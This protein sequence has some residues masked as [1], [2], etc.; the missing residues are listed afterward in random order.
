M[1]GTAYVT[2]LVV[3]HDGEPFLARTLSALRAQS[4]VPDAWVGVDAGSK[5]SSRALLTAGLPG[6][7]TVL[8]AP[9]AAFGAAVRRGVDA[10]PVAPAGTERWLW[11][12]HDD[13]APAPDALETL[14]EAIE[15]APSVTVAGTKQMDA[16][17]PDRVLDA[18]LTMTRSGRR[19]NAVAA[20]EVDQGQYDDV[21][22]VLGVNSAGL[23]VRADVFEQLDGFDPALPGVGD[24]V[25]FCRRARLSGHRVILVPAAKVLHE[26]DAVEAVSGPRAVERAAAYSCLKFAPAWAVPFLS[27]WMMIAGVG[28]AIGRLIAK[29][30]AGAVIDLGAGGTGVL[31]AGP[32]AAGR[33]RLRASQSVPRAVVRSL[34]APPDKVRDRARALRD[35]AKAEA[36]AGLGSAPAPEA[37]GGNDDFDAVEAGPRTAGSTGAGLLAIAIAAGL[38]LL[39]LHRVFGAQ[40]AAGGA[41][42]APGK[43]LGELFTAATS[44]WRELGTGQAGPADPFALLVWLSGVLS[45]GHPQAAA[46]ALYVLAMPLAA[47]G[48]F[49]LLGALTRSP[50]FRFLGAVLWALAPSLQLAL[51]Q[52]RP[53]AAV[54]HVA[55]PLF[56][57]ALV[58]SVGAARGEGLS[59]APGPGR[60]GLPSWVATCCAAALGV[61]LAAA[62]PLLL[63]PLLLLCLVGAAVSRRARGWFWIPLPAVLACLP[64]LVAAVRD[65]RVLL[66]QPG[67][68]LQ[69]DA[70]PLWQQMLGW[71]LGFDTFG[72]LPFLGALSGWPLALAVAA[73]IAVPLGVLAFLAL[74]RPA[75]GTSV[76][77]VAVLVGLLVLVLGSAASRLDAQLSGSELLHPY[78]GSFVSV[79][80][81]GV[82]VAA[83]V[84]REAFV[85]A[86]LARPAR[87]VAGVFSAVLTLSLLA[88]AAL[89]VLP[90]V[91]GESAAAF[92]TRQLVEPS[93]GRALP[94]TAAD[95]GLG[96][97]AE[98]TLVL[99]A[100]QDGALTASLVSGDGLRLEQLSAVAAAAKLSGPAWLPGHA[101]LAP[102]PAGAAAVR[103]V[104]ATLASGEQLDSRT[105]L[106]RL[107]VS[108]VVLAADGAGA[109]VLAKTLDTVPGL[110][111]V[112]RAG[113]AEA[114]IW[115]V[116]PADGEDDVQAQAGSPTARVRVLDAEGK[117]ERLI[118]SE[119]STVERAQLP[120]GAAGRTLVLS[121]S[122]DSGWKA[123]LN[124]Q[125]LT[126]TS[127]GWAQAFE[128]P[129]GGGVLEVRYASWWSPWWLLALALSLALCLLSVVPVPRSWRADARAQRVYRPS[130]AQRRHAGQAAAQAPDAEPVPE[131]VAEPSAQPQPAA[132]TSGD[133]PDEPQG[134]AASVTRP[135]PDVVRE[136]D[137]APEAEAAP[138]AVP[139]PESD[140]DVRPAPAA[141][142]AAAA[143]ASETDTEPEPYR[144]THR[145]EDA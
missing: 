118:E 135:Q 30:P 44:G 143:P 86:S 61:V 97:Y 115:R 129:Q 111:A 74:V 24:D 31:R 5:D 84:Q 16:R 59:L 34:L 120:S 106:A 35:A 87:A 65:P 1:P 49:F 11:L 70:A 4:R 41:L 93:D 27:V 38:S 64:L 62:E 102:E 126:P 56:A 101:S 132:A 92:P 71:P 99:R 91:S 32:L 47:L 69:A 42:I 98:R 15:K 19:F 124:G 90:R 137:A 75:G 125:Q 95:R 23:L 20:G 79:F 72:S 12:M 54:V 33:K 128:L 108:H 134:D 123:T 76:A 94:A 122:L 83:A 85:R 3:S 114:W 57:L 29:D 109:D 139:E 60:A 50:G 119:G 140:A 81:L 141:E 88:S 17:R 58:R 110:S 130:V 2:V 78:T 107:A 10:A 116:R 52:G 142:T 9:G 53:G 13:A 80:A 68:A 22:D 37:S 121:E 39:G 28:K 133:E 73:L 89:W 6:S 117:T 55:L 127:N 138:E 45:F 136:A 43:D 131:S 14:L 51:A 63:A 113:D 25:D 46:V 112:G 77:R 48:A 100:D 18:G 145:Q 104:V 82:L 103:S 40:A 21:S 7:A 67:A 26:P 36:E 66:V 8:E 96:R 144:G 105:E